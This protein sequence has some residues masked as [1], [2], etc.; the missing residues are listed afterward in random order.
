LSWVKLAAGGLRLTCVYDFE[1]CRMALKKLQTLLDSPGQYKAR[2]NDAVSLQRVQKEAQPPP[3]SQL[4]P[5]DLQRLYAFIDKQRQGLEHLTNIIN[6]D[7]AD[8]Q[9]IKETWRR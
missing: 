7:L 5:Q 6:D 9:L 4:S 2:L 8:M 1:L 3:T